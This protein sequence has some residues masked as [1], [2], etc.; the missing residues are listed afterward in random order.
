MSSIST[1]ILIV[2]LGPP[3]TPTLLARACLNHP[4]QSVHATGSI[5]LVELCAAPGQ[6]NSSPAIV[7]ESLLFLL[8][9]SLFISLVGL[10]TGYF[11]P[12]CRKRRWPV[13]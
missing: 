6:R 5:S 4:D 1:W 2:L 3:L 13:T 10:I 12:P 11:L 9:F 8:F 7:N